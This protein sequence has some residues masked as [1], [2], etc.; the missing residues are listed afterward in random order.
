[1]HVSLYGFCQHK[2]TCSIAAWTPEQM[3]IPHKLPILSFPSLPFPLLIPCK[4]SSTFLLLLF[5]LLD[6][7]R[8]CHL[9]WSRFEPR[10]HNP[11]SISYQ[12]TCH[13]PLL[14]AL[15]FIGTRTLSQ[16]LSQCYSD[17]LSIQLV[18]EGVRRSSI[19]ARNKLLFEP[20]PVYRF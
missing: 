16:L 7:G 9:T 5:T 14:C 17:S 12:A 18:T 10:P 2:V 20:S 8:H 6:G 15:L 4:V 13:V 3:I 1:M 11:E 19:I